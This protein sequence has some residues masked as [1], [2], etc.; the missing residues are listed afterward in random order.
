MPLTHGARCAARVKVHFSQALPRSSRLRRTKP[1]AFCIP[2]SVRQLRKVRA[3][4]RAPAH[5]RAMVARADAA[6][7][8]ATGMAAGVGESQWPFSEAVSR[9]LLSPPIRASAWA[10]TADEKPCAARAGAPL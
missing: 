6:S 10:I 3:C 9:N 7:A 1:L 5:V 8:P 2:S 4:A